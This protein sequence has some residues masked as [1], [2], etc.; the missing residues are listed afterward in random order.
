M[1][2]RDRLLGSLPWH[3]PCDIVPTTWALAT[4]QD[5]ISINSVQLNTGTA[6]L[7]YRSHHE[8]HHALLGILAQSRWPSNMPV[9]VLNQTVPLISMDWTP[10]TVHQ[11]ML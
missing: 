8:N 6:F 1:G 11:S 4:D 2:F 5:T 10:V 3:V 9:V 7:A